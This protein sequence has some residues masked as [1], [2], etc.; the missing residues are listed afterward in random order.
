MK[1]QYIM[2][3]DAAINLILGF[4]LLL[5]SERIVN[6]LGIPNT[7]QYFYPNILGGVLTGIGIA[8]IIEYYKKPGGL[9][10]LGIGG[11]VTINICGGTVLA[12]WLI[13]GRLNIPP[14]GQ[15]FL[16]ILVFILV[17]VSLIELLIYI[18]NSN[19]KETKPNYGYIAIKPFLIIGIIGLA[20]LIGAIIGFKLEGILK[21][22]IVIISL[23]VA[24]IGIYIS[25]AYIPL[26]NFVIKSRKDYAFWDKVLKKENISINSKV[27][28]VG[29]GTG[30]VSI[31]VAKYIKSGHVTGLDIFKGMSGNS[32]AR[33][34]RNAEIE[35]VANRT[36]FKHGNLLDIPFPDNTFDLITAGSVLHEV[37]EE[38]DKIKALN[39]IYRVLK[40]GGK[41]I[42]V[43]IIRDIRLAIAVMVF[44]F[45][46]K[47]DSY[48]IKLFNKSKFKLIN[49]DYMIRLIK[50]GTYI[51]QK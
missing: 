35:G 46:W 30:Q 11:A 29:C 18:K 9:S 42:T 23:P 24:F 50:M 39:E 51:L 22:I 3:V 12:A 48:W 1:K 43:E 4:L 41:F 49:A 17:F 7:S 47:T 16:W 2:L 37:H 19:S 45:V 25:L 34:I 40:P 15:I 38:K 33:P 27:L 6:L 13:F 28:D 20:G 8:L 26:Y 31:E 44:V 32:P 10:G 14:H 21:T 36:E 5:F